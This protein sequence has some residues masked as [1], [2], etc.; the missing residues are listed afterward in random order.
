MFPGNTCFQVATTLHNERN[1]HLLMQFV[2]TFGLAVV[3]IPSLPRDG[4][5]A[6]TAIHVHAGNLIE[7]RLREDGS[8]FQTNHE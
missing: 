3:I 7:I 8:P 1:S 5:T 2:Q 6:R 4:G